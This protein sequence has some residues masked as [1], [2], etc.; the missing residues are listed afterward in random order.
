MLRL[1]LGLELAA[2]ERWRPPPGAAAT[3][4]LQLLAVL[5]LGIDPVRFVA[6]AP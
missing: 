6:A 2:R 1:R 5:Q 3:T 4:G